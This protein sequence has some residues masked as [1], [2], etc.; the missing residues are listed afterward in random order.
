MPG[1][2]LCTHVPMLVRLIKSGLSA[3]NCSIQETIVSYLKQ[4]IQV[5][6]T[7][8]SSCVTVTASFNYFFS[9]SLA[10]LSHLW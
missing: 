5:K 4:I 3:A 6:A 2:R 7:Q 1:A 9:R 8:Y 10:L